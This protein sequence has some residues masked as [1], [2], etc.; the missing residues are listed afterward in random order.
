MDVQ[1]YF[2]VEFGYAHLFKGDYLA[3]VPMSPAT[4]NSNFVYAA[5]NFKTPL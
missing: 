5:V 1:D 3:R 2:H 4:P